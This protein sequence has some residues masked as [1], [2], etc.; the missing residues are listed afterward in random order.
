[1]CTVFA[2]SGGDRKGAGKGDEESNMPLLLNMQDAMGLAVG[3]LT[4]ATDPSDKI[5]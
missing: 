3:S 2:A 4:G 1:M 5:I